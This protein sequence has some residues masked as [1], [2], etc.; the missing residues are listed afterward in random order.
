MIKL[1]FRFNIKKKSVRDMSKTGSGFNRI[2]TETPV[3]KTHSEMSSKS[4]ILHH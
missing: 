4:E 1:V 3:T 2:P